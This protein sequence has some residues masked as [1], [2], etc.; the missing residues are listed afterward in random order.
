MPIGEYFRSFIDSIISFKKSEG[1]EGG[2]QAAEGI[3]V[4]NIT[5]MI[6]DNSSSDIK[7]FLKKI[8][9]IQFHRWIMK[10]C[11][12]GTQEQMDELLK[13]ESDWETL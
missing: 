4:E 12:G 10:E 13:A 5:E 3:S 11:N 6:N 8:W 9:L 2:G 7:V 1:G